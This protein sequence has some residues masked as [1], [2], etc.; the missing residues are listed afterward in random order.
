MPFNYVCESFIN[1]IFNKKHRFMGFIQKYRNKPAILLLVLSAFANGTLLYFG[2]VSQ[3]ITI[4]ISVLLWVGWLITLR[5]TLKHIMLLQFTF[6]LLTISILHFTHFFSPFLPSLLTFFNIYVAIQGVL[7]MYFAG[8]KDEKMAA[9]AFLGVQVK[10]TLVLLLV[11]GGILYALYFVQYIQFEVFIYRFVYLQFILVFTPIG[12]LY[13]IT[14]RYAEREKIFGAH[15]KPSVALIKRIGNLRILLFSRPGLITDGKF[16]LTELNFRWS[17]K[18]DTILS[19]CAQLMAQS[20]PEVAQALEKEI[21]NKENIKQI[22]IISSQKAMVTGQD[23]EGK[24]YSLTNVKPEVLKNNPE[25]YDYYLILDEKVIAQFSLTENTLPDASE[26]IRIANKL[27]F[28]NAIICKHEHP[29][30]LSIKNSLKTDK[31]Y[32]CE[33]S[34]EEQALVNRLSAKA[35]LAWISAAENHEKNNA[36]SFLIHPENN[37]VPASENSMHIASAKELQTI[38]DF[39]VNIKQHIDWRLTMGLTLNIVLVFLVILMPLHLHHVVLANT[40][41]QTTNNLVNKYF[42]LLKFKNEQQ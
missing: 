19:I 36:F 35:P 21:E 1:A 39:A 42:I 2:A 28:N 24:K 8:D 6:I 14:A 11:G 7:Y 17:Y 9:S 4:V 25:E 18:R 27:Q 41:V 26:Y 37:I 3:V 22:E 33:N 13:H 10:G 40:A 29:S 20:F 15:A 16:K 12:Y 23:A 34:N 32:V 5:R 38:L 31:I 30:N